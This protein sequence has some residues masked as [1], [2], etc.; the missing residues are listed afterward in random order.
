MVLFQLQLKNYLLTREINLQIRCDQVT[1]EVLV[2]NV[3]CYYVWYVALCFTSLNCL[4]W[5]FPRIH[6]HTQFFRYT[7][8]PTLSNT[9]FL[10]LLILTGER[11]TSILYEELW[12]KHGRPWI[13]NELDIV[14]H[15]GRIMGCYIF[16]YVKCRCGCVVA[17]H[18]LT[19]SNIKSLMNLHAI[20]F[21]WDCKQIEK[22]IFRTLWRTLDLR[23]LSTE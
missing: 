8:N 3:V 11:H 15:T 19:K 21:L 23:N 4:H 5:N 2:F 6:T 16:D 22:V 12:N 7:L 10:F 13:R 18:K 17:S 14:C 20:L 1:F 9:N